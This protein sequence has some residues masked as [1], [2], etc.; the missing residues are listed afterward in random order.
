MN[1]FLGAHKKWRTAFDFTMHRTQVVW[2]LISNLFCDQGLEKLM[3]GE[4]LFSVNLARGMV[5]EGIS[6]LSF[7]R[8]CIKNY[9]SLQN[10]RR[11]RTDSVTRFS[12]SVVRSRFGWPNGGCYRSVEMEKGEPVSCPNSCGRKRLDAVR[13][14]RNFLI[15]RHHSAV[16]FWVT[17]FLGDIIR[18]RNLSTTWNKC[19]SALRP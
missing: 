1:R 19:M 16:R 14:C 8:R 5:N 6:A 9:Y 12:T 17:G 10:L 2:K 3:R 4:Q 15:D 11:I 18:Y 7:L 13:L